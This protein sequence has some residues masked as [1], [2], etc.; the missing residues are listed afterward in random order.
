MLVL[1]HSPAV[2]TDVRLPQTW[3]REKKYLMRS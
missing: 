3:P 2:T 1:K